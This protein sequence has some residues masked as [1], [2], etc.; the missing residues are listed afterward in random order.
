MLAAQ[1]VAT[2]QRAKKSRRLSVTKTRTEVHQNGSTVTTQEKQTDTETIEIENR[3]TVET[4][5]EFKCSVLESEQEILSRPPVSIINNNS[6]LKWRVTDVV[7]SCNSFNRMTDNPV[8]IQTASDIFRLC[9]NR[10]PGHGFLARYGWD[11]CWD[12][13]ELLWA[14]ESRIER[15]IQERT[16]TTTDSLEFGSLESFMNDFMSSVFIDK[17]VLY[18][19]YNYDCSRMA[20]PVCVG[21]IST[22]VSLN[23]GVDTVKSIGGM[24]FVFPVDP[25]LRRRLHDWRFCPPIQYFPLDLMRLQDRYRIVYQRQLEEDRKDMLDKRETDVGYRLHLANRLRCIKG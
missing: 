24:E 18:A 10:L 22:I 25:S 6:Y 20:W 9:W 21:S 12:F 15:C 5:E 1:V 14:E 16:P 13:G 7:D 3:V 11:V 2:R 17:V 4:Q 8:E 23:W 19:Y